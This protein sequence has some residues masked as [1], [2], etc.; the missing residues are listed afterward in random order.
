MGVGE[1]EHGKYEKVKIAYM[2]GVL[3]VIGLMG[4]KIRLQKCGTGRG[5][6]SSASQMA[7]NDF[8]PLGFEPPCN[9]LLFRP[10]LMIQF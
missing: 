10:H 2:L 5:L 7:S 9:S 3:R 4:P 6:W 1:R 8:H